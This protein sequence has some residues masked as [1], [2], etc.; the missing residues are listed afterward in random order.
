MVVHIYA[1]S[2]G[3]NNVGDRGAV[4]IAR[5]VKSSRTIKSLRLQR[6]SIGKEGGRALAEAI[7]ANDTLTLFNVSLNSLG[8]EV[9]HI[10]D[11]VQDTRM[12]LISWVLSNQAFIDCFWLVLERVELCASVP[13]FYCLI[14]YQSFLIIGKMDAFLLC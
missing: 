11:S 13:V 7:Q 2:L 5:A 1:H 4:A 9:R 14:V 6:N 3:R 10:G 12:L 8:H